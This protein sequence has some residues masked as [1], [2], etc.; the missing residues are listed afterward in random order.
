MHDLKANFDIIYDKLKVLT[1]DIL[2]TQGNLPRPGPVP[3]F[4]DLEV[5][6]LSLTA[7]YLS[8]DSENHLYM[9]LRSDYGE[10]FPQ[11]IDRTNYNRRKRHLSALLAVVH[12][13]LANCLTE[14]EDTF[15]VDSEPLPICRFSRASGCRSCQET[16]W[17]L[18]S[19]GYC[20][21]QKQTYFGYKFHAVV[22]PQGVIKHFD[23]SAAHHHD[24]GFL[25]DIARHLSD[26]RLIGDKAYLSAQI[27]Q[28]LQ[29]SNHIQLYTPMKRNQKDYQPLPK[30]MR[31]LRKR[32]ETVFS[33]L[34]GQFN[35]KRNLAITF[36][37]LKTRVL[38]KVAAFTLIQ[39]FNRFLFYR[40]IDHVKVPIY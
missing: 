25:K 30:P 18:P 33:Q 28:Q 13:R 39:F 21:S 16:D 35:L 27:Q 8:I 24:I 40:E 36:L 19:F 31:R 34:D 37:E 9:K 12:H 32:I 11:L 4:S 14:G 26:C 15:V 17:A 2:T 20:A 10:R 6:S 1:Q 38:A 7:E 22:S 23:L 5:M 3:K 29:L